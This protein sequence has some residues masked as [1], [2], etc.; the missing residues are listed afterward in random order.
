M[1][2]GSIIVDLSLGNGGCLETAYPSSES[3]EPVSI[4]NGVIHYRVH[5]I[6]SRVARTSSIALSNIFAPILL[7]LAMA[8]GLNN[9]I[10]QDVGFSHGLYLYKGILT[11]HTVGEKFNLPAKDIGLLMAAF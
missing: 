4:H 6:A 7:R 5:N 9:L 1:K 3:G 8:G 11:N 10:K 2:P